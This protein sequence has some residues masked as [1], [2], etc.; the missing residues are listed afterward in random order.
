M[1]TPAEIV[2]EI[3]EWGAEGWIIIGIKGEEDLDI[4]HQSNIEDPEIVREVLTSLLGE[5]Y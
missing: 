3:E 4:N 5:R 1:K 2:K